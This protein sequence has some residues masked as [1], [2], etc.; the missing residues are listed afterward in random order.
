MD[1]LPN[2]LI[3]LIM[4]FYWMQS[5]R[6]VARRKSDLHQELLQKVQRTTTT[7]R[8][9]SVYW[10]FGDL[11]ITWLF[12]DFDSKTWTRQVRLLG[13][14]TKTER[15]T[16]VMVP[17]TDKKQEFDNYD[18]DPDKCGILWDCDITTGIYL[19]KIKNVPS[20]DE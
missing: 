3:Q 15:I 8:D 6:Y 11:C 12:H 17:F 18:F 13:Y 2:E 9:L 4:R 7:A 1:Q 20:I 14:N 10:C 16:T 19:N 5:Q